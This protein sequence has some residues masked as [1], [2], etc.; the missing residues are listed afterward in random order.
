M[1]IQARRATWRGRIFAW[2]VACLLFLSGRVSAQAVRGRV[3][4]SKTHLAL[5][6]ALVELRDTSG[7]SLLVQ[8]TPSSGAFLLTAPAAGRYLLR[9]VAIGYTP[10]RSTPIALS[11]VVLSL[12][13][14]PL[15]P[16][17]VRLPDLVV[18]ARQRFCGNTGFSDAVF[19]QLLE[20][21]RTALQVIEAT[22]QSRQVGFQVT[23]V[24]SRILYGPVNNFI[25]A[26]TAVRL[27]ATWPVRSVAAD[28]L[29]TF[30]FGRQLRPGD[31]GSREYYGPDPQVLFSDWF[32][33]SH[34][35]TLAK[36]R[37]GNDTLLVRFAPVRKDRKIDIR[38]ELML[39][40][41]N[42]SLHAMTFA[43]IN[44]PSWMPEEAAG[45]EMQFFQT[46]NGLW[47]TR[48]WAIWAP[49]AGLTWAG[50]G[51]LT[52]AGLAEV[53]GYVTRILLDSA[54]AHR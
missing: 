21:A 23:I 43:H 49:I 36:V 26:D 9:V 46:P 44:L 5:P 7:R 40:A 34:C 41:K 3:I 53:R 27:L 11:E 37:K 8:I 1:R 32:L 25:T 4:D 6:G 14:I 38:G 50:D 24:T 10:R 2:F 28:T 18:V 33:A 19:G 17:S 12:P 29:R 16:V 42:L 47:V 54:G 39:D 20:G 52:M 30:G 13:D 48:N 15:T 31:E 51:G 35:F 45:G 22:I